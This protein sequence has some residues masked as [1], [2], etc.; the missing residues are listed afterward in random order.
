MSKL[1]VVGLPHTFVTEEYSAC[2]YTQKVRKF[3][4][5]MEAQ[6][7]EVI[8]HDPISPE[9][10][11]GFGFNG[12][13]DYLK[14]DF[15]SELPIW[16]LL[17]ERLI[18][19]LKDAPSTDI[20]CLITGQPHE[21]LVSKV[22]M[23]TVEFGVGY[24]GVLN[25]TFRVFESNAWRN[26][27]YGSYKADVSFYD[28][29]IP[30]YYEIEKFPVVENPDDYFAFVGRMIDKKGYRIAEKVCEDMGYD[31]IL[32]GQGKK[33]DYGSYMGMLPYNE[34]IEIMAHAKALF[35]PTTYVAPFEGVHIEAQLCG[36]PVITT[37]QG[38]FQETVVN[39]VNGYRCKMYRDFVEASEK[40]SQLDR[41]SIANSAREKYS[42][43]TVG[44]QYADYFE[45]LDTL[46]GAGWYA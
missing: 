2:A 39:G 46:N 5:M 29:V 11:I 28:E 34:T 4:P 9:E 25:G 36:T 8:L 33:P 31:L 3:I 35:V 45:R 12:P 7:F 38:V 41:L 17:N 1:H 16:R 22:S 24:Q 15:N 27:V 23:K 10:K 32:V 6:G 42:L 40:I 20:L 21:E 37:D 44:R 30:N 26:Y 13:E 18:E 43:E 14:I 19:E